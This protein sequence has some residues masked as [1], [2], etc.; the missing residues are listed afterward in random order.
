MVGKSPENSEVVRA[1]FRFW[2]PQAGATIEVGAERRQF[3]L[4]QLPL[5]VRS[6]CGDPEAHDI[7]Q[8]TYDYL[9]QFPDAP[10]AELYAE[11]LRDAFPHFLS[12]LAAQIVM[13]NEKEVDAPFV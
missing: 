8:G 4:P 3:P 6:V 2:T 12:D 13:I 7:G 10:S 1:G 11:L 5:P 9:R